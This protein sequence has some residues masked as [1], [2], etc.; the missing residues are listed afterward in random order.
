MGVA[1]ELNRNALEASTS[2]RRLE[3]EEK[4]EGKRKKAEVICLLLD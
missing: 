2:K 1:A 3:V 4:A